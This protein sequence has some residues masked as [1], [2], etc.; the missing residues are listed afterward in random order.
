MFEDAES[1]VGGMPHW[2]VDRKVLG[3]YAARQRW[4]TGKRVEIRSIADISH[5]L[6]DQR[7]FEL[8]KPKGK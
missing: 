5:Y 6:T 8:N 7:E 3:R 2:A 1:A 4:E